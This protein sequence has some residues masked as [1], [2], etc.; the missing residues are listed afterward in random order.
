MNRNSRKVD[1]LILDAAYNMFTTQGISFFTM[2][3]IAARL[4]V[5][6]KTLYRFFNSRHELV[7]YVS[8][9]VAE[10]YEKAVAAAAAS[11]AGQLQK[12]V[13]FMEANIHFCKKISPLFFSD[14]QKHYPLE[15]SSLES[16]ISLV[17]NQK[18]EP[19]LTQGIKSGVFREDLQPPLVVA[20][21]DRHLRADF[22]L[23][24]EQVCTYP[25][26]EVFRQSIRLFLF[27]IIAPGAIAELHQELTE[28]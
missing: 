26:D 10:N 3:D 17:F 20:I 11:S 1:E 21:M 16:A 4:A 19:A 7:Q 6:K 13:G 14:L 2:D 25:K 5:S 12:L 9:L 15:H 8:G 28:H 23:A 24:S 22:K 18:L 27:G